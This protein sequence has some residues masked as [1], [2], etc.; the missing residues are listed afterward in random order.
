MERVYI[1]M[2][3]EVEPGVI[4]VHEFIRCILRHEKE[5]YEAS[6]CVD[7]EKGSYILNQGVKVVSLKEFENSALYESVSNS[8]IAD[9]YSEYINNAT[10][11][12]GNCRH[13]TLMS[14]HHWNDPGWCSALRG[15][16]MPYWV[17]SRGRTSAKKGADCDLF[18]RKR[19]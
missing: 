17:K 14:A 13:F 3:D 7:W 8:L 2:P 10:K 11:S 15:I 18:G 5:Y 9:I 12:C 16:K 1:D 6:D 4:T 19:R